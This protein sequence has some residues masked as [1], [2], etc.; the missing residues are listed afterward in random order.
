MTR[1]VLRFLI[2]K[3]L[4][5]GFI[6]GC[7]QP[8]D[9]QGQSSGEQELVNICASKEASIAGCAILRAVNAA[10]KDE[11]VSEAQ[12]ASG[13]AQDIIAYRAGADG[14]LGTADDVTFRTLAEVS[15]LAKTTV[16]VL[17]RLGYF[18][19][20][21]GYGSQCQ[22]DTTPPVVRRVTFSPTTV[23][24]TSLDRPVKVT[25]D[26]ADDLGGVKYA[27]V[28]LRGPSGQLYPVTLWPSG[29]VVTGSVTIP[30][31]SEPGKYRVVYLTATDNAG[32][33]VQASLPNPK[34]AG[35]DITTLALNVTNTAADT[36]PPVASALTFSPASA[37]VTNT[38]SEIT[39]ILKATDNRSGVA[40]YRID[41]VGPAAR[42]FLVMLAPSVPG[43]LRGKFTVPR[44]A[45]PGRYQVTYLEGKDVAGN[46]VS[47]NLANP[48]AG[49][50][51]ISKLFLDIKASVSDTTP[52][53]AR[54]LLFSAA[55]IDTSGSDQRV[56]LQLEATDD[57]SGVESYGIYF[58]GPGD[59]LLATTLLPNGTGMLTGSITFPRFS[60]PGPYQLMLLT[61]RDL[62]WNTSKS[63]LA[64]PTG[65]GLDISNLAIVV[66]AP[67]E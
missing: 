3:S 51:D 56:D 12:L 48:T 55:T 4:C 42:S 39:I 54:N 22:A 7:G 45:S 8:G 43:E 64:N 11:L 63:D 26:I 9:V 60:P 31:Y 61:G 23:D 32:N 53:V 57:L 59:R 40:S 34:A 46:T 35:V 30:R 1:A 27:T 24:V 6:A 66:T 37:D 67:A 17:W 44:Y 15:G 2:V 5:V 25:A 65:S 20:A 52:P 14:K 41:V 10:T 49:G 19:G 21:K 13:E 62:L 16:N 28:Q 50:I 36:T 38:S 47:S 33:T 29:C 18:A 58:T